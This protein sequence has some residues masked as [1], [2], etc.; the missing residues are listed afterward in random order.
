MTAVMT[1]EGPLESSALGVTLPHEHIFSNALLE[2]RATGGILNDED[3]AIRELLLYVKAGGNTLIDVTTGEIGRDPRG[4]RRVA[5]ATGLNIVMGSGHYRDPYLDRDWF[6]RMSVDDIASEI[7][8]DIREG[9]DGT[10]VRSGI[11][12]EI[13][14]DKWYI[15]AAEERS[16]RAAGRAHLETGVTIST[17]AARWPVGL[18]QLDVLATEGV[19][20]GRVIIGHADTVPSVEYHLAVARRGAFVSFDGFG[21][22]PEYDAER[23]LK[24]IFRLVE[25]G[26]FR[27][28]LLSQDVF[29]K[30]QL[31]AYGGN[32][33]DYVL[34]KLVPTLHD[35]GISKAHVETMLTHNVRRALTGEDE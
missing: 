5:T 14:A 19:E 22:E 4:L 31:H 21:T 18:L 10:G 13:G 9:V 30:S 17:H 1:V 20:P 34:T 8:R 23:S 15:S 3:L 16:F 27:Q 6:D 26:H 28:I 29:Q 33:Y 2:Y 35:R 12:G 32:G 24:S 25:E 7:V 11:I